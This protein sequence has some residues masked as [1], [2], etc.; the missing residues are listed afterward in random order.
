MLIFELNRSSDGLYD[1]K[2]GQTKAPNPLA[3]GGQ[4]VMSGLGAS[5]A[6]ARCCGRSVYV[7]IKF[8]PDSTFPHA[9]LDRHDTG[10]TSD[11]L[12]PTWKGNQPKAEGNHEEAHKGK[13]TENAYMHRT[14]DVHLAFVLRKLGAAKDIPNG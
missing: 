10:R 3:L 2:V 14:Y 13:L 4:E 12:S 7:S 5:T 8:H 11:A 1:S 6:Q 9:L